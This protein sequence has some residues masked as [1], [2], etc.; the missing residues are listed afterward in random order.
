MSDLIAIAFDDEASAFELRAELVRMQKEYLL[1]LEDA[2][3]VTRKDGKVQL[4]QAANMTAIGATGGTMW[5]MLIGLIFLNPLAGAVIGLA[6]GAL[7]GALTDVGIQD[8]FIREV[9]QAVQPGG[10]AVFL[11]VRK[12]TADKVLDRLKEAAPRGRIMRTSLSQEDED[13][14]RAAISDGAPG[15]ATAVPRI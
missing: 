9:G 8:D 5:G 1:Q 2:V 6:G 14:L 13:R 15:E 3:V 12:M 11:L 7:A 10:S 4:H